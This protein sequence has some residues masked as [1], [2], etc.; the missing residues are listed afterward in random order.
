M[1]DAL[2]ATLRDACS[3]GLGKYSMHLAGTHGLHA[4]AWHN[5]FPRPPVHL[6][7]VEPLRLPPL[8]L[9]APEDNQ[10]SALALEPTVQSLVTD[11]L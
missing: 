10:S 1:H 9:F 6:A 8:T 11:P 3:A 2:R 7:H 5:G 4:H